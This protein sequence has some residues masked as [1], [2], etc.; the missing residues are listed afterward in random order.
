MRMTMNGHVARA[1][2]RRHTCAAV[3][4]S[5]VSANADDLA[6]CSDAEGCDVVDRILGAPEMWEPSLIGYRFREPF[7]ADWKAEVGRWLLLAEQLGFIDPLVKL[8]RKRVL[9]EAARP[10]V[11]GANDSAHLYLGQELAAAMTVY[12]LARS[13]WVFVEW[14][15]RLPDGV[16][17]DVDIRLRCPFGTLTD[18]QVKAPDQPGERS[19]GQVVD[20]EYDDRICTAIDKALMQVHV[21]PGPQRMVVVSPQRLWHTDERRLMTHLVGN[22]VGG[23][24][25]VT[26][27]ALNRGVFARTPGNLVGAAMRLTLSR[28]ASEKLYRCTVFVNPWAPASTT[29]AVMAFRNARVCYLSENEFLWTPEPPQLAG[30]LPPGTRYIE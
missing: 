2:L 7:Q 21:A 27:S 14:E 17:G 25:G 6:I 11:T 13:G 19:D 1:Y 30:V 12:Y 10:K 29:P 22:T 20:G 3:E 8:I 28:G 9:K 23:A 4:E 5:K 15:P 16:K 24:G 18:I 26:L